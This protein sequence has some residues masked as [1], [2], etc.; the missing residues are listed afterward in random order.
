MRLIKVY[1]AVL[2]IIAPHRNS[3]KSDRAGSLLVKFA[4]MLPVVLSISLGGMDYAWTLTHKSVLQNAA[5][6]AAL[7]AA[8]EISL[9]GAGRHDLQ[10]AV[11]EIAKQYVS[12]NR[13]SLIKKDAAPPKVTAVIRYDPHEVEVNISQ[14][15]ESLVGSMF[16]LQFPDL[17]L[18]SVA[19][20]VGQPNICVLGL[21]QNDSRTIALD[22]NARMTGNDCAVY[23]NSANSQGLVSKDSAILVANMICSRGGTAGSADNFNPNPFLDCPG[24][25]DPLANRAEPTP[26]NCITLKPMV[27]GVVATLF[28]GTYCGGL[29]IASG[30]QAIL[31]PGVYV[32]KDGPLIVENGASL[33]GVGVGLYYVGVDAT[34]RFEDRTLISLA[35]PIAGPMAGMLMFESR[36]RPTSGRN[37]HPALALTHNSFLLPSP[38]SCV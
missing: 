12:R 14:R 1:K 38:S 36:T 30:A 19:R 28:P 26:G 32:F 33:T 24:F 27:P 17:K 4:M 16:G 2:S 31:S 10:S 8:K 7:A 21:E 29:V 15:V 13:R 6:A 9:A 37:N 11:E 5:D 25:D 18:S 22:E 3:F 35:A 23:S 34:F 20:I